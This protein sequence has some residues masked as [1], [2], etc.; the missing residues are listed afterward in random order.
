MIVSSNLTNATLYEQLNFNFIRDIAPVASI[1]GARF[2]MV[3][4]P[5]FPAKTVPE[6]IAYAKANPGKISMA[7]PGNGTSPHVFGELFKMITG[8]DML[9]VPYHGSYFA[10]LIGGQV[11]VA[12]SAL[13]VSIAYIRTRELRALAVT[14]AT[15]SEALPDIPSAAE[16]VPGYEARGLEG[17]GVPKNTAPEIIETLNK[18]INAVVADPKIKAR[19]VG[20]GVE[21]MSMTPAEFRKF[22]AEETEKWGEVVR[23]AKIKPE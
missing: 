14:T 13:P 23:T 12:F 21:P 18:E 2:I 1:G 16:F 11:Q 6:F 8:I 3:V 4:L 5:S 7:S 20:L 19:L 22:I 9:H 17:I 15:R 10:D